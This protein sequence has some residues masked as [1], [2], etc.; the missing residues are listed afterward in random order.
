[1]CSAFAQYRLPPLKCSIARSNLLCPHSDWF[2]MLTEHLCRPAETSA[3]RFPPLLS[4]CWEE[5][6]SVFTSDRKQD[7][8]LTSELFTALNIG[9]WIHKNYS[10]CGTFCKFCS[11]SVT[12]NKFLTV[13]QCINSGCH[14]SLP[15][16]LGGLIC[17]I[18]Q[19][20]SI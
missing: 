1:M 16:E 3:Y 10:I 12:V 11:R 19:S 13:V 20:L 8:T 6:L 17:G 9:S 15:Q 7:I 4:E 5:I 2:C 18:L 14:R